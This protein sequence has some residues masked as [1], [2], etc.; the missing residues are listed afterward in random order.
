MHVQHSV[1][2]GNC[3]GA[4]GLLGLASESVFVLWIDAVGTVLM[5]IVAT[6]KC[7]QPTQPTFSAVRRRHVIQPLHPLAHVVGNAIPTLE[8]VHAVLVTLAQRVKLLGSVAHLHA[9][10]IGMMYSCLLCLW[11]VV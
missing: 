11:L 7:A 10:F 8:C 4:L 1:S 2:A 9:V 6:C 3:Y 5:I